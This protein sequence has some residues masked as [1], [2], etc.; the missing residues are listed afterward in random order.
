MQKIS[1]TDQTTR[2]TQTKDCEETTAFCFLIPWISTVLTFFVLVT[3]NDFLSINLFWNSIKN[4]TVGTEYRPL[5]DP[6]KI[7][8]SG[9][10][11]SSKF[12]TEYFHGWVDVAFLITS[13]EAKGRRQRIEEFYPQNMEYPYDTSSNS[14]SIAPHCMQHIQSNWHTVIHRK[15]ENSEK[16]KE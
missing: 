8:P 1:S 9:I 11:K 3:F 2:I 15:G 10:L 13:Q 5:F 16:S 14:T 12:C 4:S 7:D 6:V